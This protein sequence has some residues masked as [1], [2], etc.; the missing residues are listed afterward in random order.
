[1][2]RWKELFFRG[3]NAYFFYKGAWLLWRS[4][5]WPK[6]WFTEGQYSSNQHYFTK[7]SVLILIIHSSTVWAGPNL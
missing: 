7:G 6:P 1:M 2:E 5:D 3:S 4:L